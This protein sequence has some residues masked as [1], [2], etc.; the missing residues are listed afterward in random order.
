M[1]TL[2]EVEIRSEYVGVRIALHCMVELRHSGVALLSGNP[3][4]LRIYM[5]DDLVR[6]L[7]ASGT[8][9]LG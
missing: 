2:D 5:L 3:L 9:K 8:L 7:L 4:R 6:W 1:T